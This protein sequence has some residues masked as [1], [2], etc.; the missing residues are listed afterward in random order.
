MSVAPSLEYL[1]LAGVTRL[2]V[3]SARGP[4]DAFLFDPHRLAFPCWALTGAEGP[5]ALLVTLDRHFDLVPPSTPVPQKQAGLRALD[6]HARWELDVRNVD[7]VLAAMEAGLLGDA[8]V[9]ARANPLGSFEGERWTDR[10]GKAHQLIR[11]PTVDRLSDGFGGP[12]ASATTRSLE[13]L[14]ANAPRVVLDIDLDCFTSPSDADPTAVIPW[15]RA[16]IR[17]HLM[18]PGSEPFWSAVLARCDVLTFAREP[19]HCGGV[20]EGNRLF[21]EAAEVVFRDLLGADLP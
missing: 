8:V 15:S 16:L 2:H 3:A 10:H 9:I 4:K 5:A 17:E 19:A 11:A 12:G 21:A 20:V 1:R 13:A 14:L 18:P 7:H 6:E